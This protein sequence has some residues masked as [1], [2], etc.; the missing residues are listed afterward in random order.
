MAM[1]SSSSMAT[2]PSTSTSSNGHGA[3]AGGGREQFPTILYNMLELA[4]AD[5]NM[6][7]PSNWGVY[8]FAWCEHGRAFRIIDRLQFEEVLPL[9]FKA[10]KLRSFQ[11][12]LNLWQFERIKS[13]PDKDAWYHQHFRRG[14]PEYMKKMIRVKIKGNAGN[15]RNPSSHSK[16]GAGGRH[17]DDL[18][19][20]S[21]SSS[22]ASSP[23]AI[24]TIP[25]PT[26]MK[27]TMVMP[28]EEEDSSVA[29]LGSSAYKSYARRITD[30]G[31]PIVSKK[32]TTP[33]KEKKTKYDPW[34]SLMEARPPSPRH[35]RCISNHTP[36]YT[37]P[38][39]TT[40]HHPDHNGSGTMFYYSHPMDRMRMM[41]T[42]A[43][44]QLY[45]SGSFNTTCR[46]SFSQEPLPLPSISSSTAGEL[47]SNGLSERDVYDEGEDEFDRYIDSRIH[48]VD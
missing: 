37:I 21:S 43:P 18:H 15:V 38:T 12:Q 46:S 28:T 42:Q 17:G 47:F 6:R 35:S 34:Q 20:I 16:D 39:T 2:T 3:G 10:T 45:V 36:S 5:N 33:K 9:F 29:L 14:H 13:G 4:A 23:P 44:N 30:I 24:S 48:F 32:L 41:A 22:S 40:D 31:D 27:T 1:E 8:P 11:R 25:I 19:P 7:S 26:H